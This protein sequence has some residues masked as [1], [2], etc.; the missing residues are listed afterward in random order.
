MEFDSP[1]LVDFQHL[2]QYGVVKDLK[3]KKYI[4]L[5]QWKYHNV[6]MCNTVIAVHWYSNISTKYILPFFKY[7]NG[8]PFEWTLIRKRMWKGW[9]KLDYKQ[10]VFNV[11]YILWLWTWIFWPLNIEYTIPFILCVF[12]YHW[13]RIIF[14]AT[15][16]CKVLN[17]FSFTSS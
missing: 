17:T 8:K 10:G 5:N 7:M 3:R 16:N 9:C 11:K 2:L 1:C 15:C 6:Y 12:N 13:F 14:G 4:S